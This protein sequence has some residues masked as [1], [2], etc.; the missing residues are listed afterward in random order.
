MPLWLPST[1]HQETRGSKY[2][3]QGY[4]PRP[5]FL[6]GGPHPCLTG[7]HLNLGQRLAYTVAGPLREGHEGD[8]GGTRVAGPACPALQWVLL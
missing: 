1:A 4:S 3:Q 8:A 6:Y 5:A 7:P 2:P